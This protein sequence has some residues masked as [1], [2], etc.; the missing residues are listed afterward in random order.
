MLIFRFVGTRAEAA[1]QEEKSKS[2]LITEL[3]KGEKSG[4]VEN[5]DRKTFV[6]SL[7]AQYKQ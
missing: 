5:F 1:E 2:Q 3:K 6:K 4:F 7:H